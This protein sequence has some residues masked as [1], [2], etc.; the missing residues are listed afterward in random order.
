MVSFVIL[1]D[2]V[3]TFVRAFNNPDKLTNDFII[4]KRLK[5]NDMSLSWCI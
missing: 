5:N 2:P 4:L 3:T 1:R